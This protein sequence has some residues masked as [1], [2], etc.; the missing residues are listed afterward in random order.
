MKAGFLYNSGMGL[1][2]NVSLFEHG[3]GLCRQ[4]VTLI[5][6]CLNIVMED[7]SLIPSPPASYNSIIK[8]KWYKI[9]V[10][11]PRGGE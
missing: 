9:K 4:L 8:I 2:D 7:N 11:G 10:D 6:L 1:E 3:G 5:L